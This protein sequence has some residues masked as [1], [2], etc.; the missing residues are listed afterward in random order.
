MTK[1]VLFEK[2][3]R[4]CILFII[5]LSAIGCNNKP[6]TNSTASG[7]T[8]NELIA[9]T[10]FYPVRIKNIDTTDVWADSRLKK[11]NS[12]RLVDDIF[13]SVYE[14]KSTAYNYLTDQPLTVEEVKNIESKEDFSRDKVVELEFREKWWYSP[15]RSVFKKEVLS[16]LVAYAVYD[17]FGDFSRMKAAFYIKINQ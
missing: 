6:A 15:D 1:P 9:D 8:T 10:I 11:L 16:I 14:G 13:K 7:F 2:S 12:N 3:T 17:E 5:I 4:I